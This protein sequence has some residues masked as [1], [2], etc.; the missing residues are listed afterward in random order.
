MSA[1]PTNSYPLPYQTPPCTPQAPHPPATPTLP[2]HHLLLITPNHPNLQRSPA[3]FAPRAPHPPANPNMHTANS[4]PPNNPHLVY[5]PAF[6]VL[7]TLCTPSLPPPPP[8]CV[9]PHLVFS[10][11]CVPPHY[12]HYPHLVYSPT[13]ATARR[14]MPPFGWRKFSSMASTTLACCAALIGRPT[15][16]HAHT[17]LHTASR[18]TSPPLPRYKRALSMAGM[19]LATCECECVC[20]CVR[21]GLCVRVS[22]LVCVSVCDWVYVCLLV[23]EGLSNV[24]MRA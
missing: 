4:S 6:C 22:M 17:S 14:W 21:V 11:P 19:R 9:L 8:P 5:S 2:T 20:V 7:P 23:C 16:A 15:A 24:C 12:P 3:Y 18:I 10:P 13:A 1:A